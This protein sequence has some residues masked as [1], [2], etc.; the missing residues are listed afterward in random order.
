V[1]AARSSHRETVPCRVGMVIWDRP[2]R[3]YR[4]VRLEMGARRRHECA[5][6][7][8]KRT[9]PG[10]PGLRRARRAPRP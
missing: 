4:A 2:R 10:S 9:G 5:G 1:S 7:R 6:C 8:P 3:A